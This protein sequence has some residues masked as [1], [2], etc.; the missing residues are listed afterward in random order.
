RKLNREGLEQL[1]EGL[2]ALDLQWIPSIGNFLTV[3]VGREAAPVYEALLRLGVI[4]RP[5]ANYG[6]P[7]HLRVTVGTKA[8]NARFLESMALVL[9][10]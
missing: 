6:L 7:N 10:Q 3:D 9:G 8:Q 4:V 5:L 2:W 1:A